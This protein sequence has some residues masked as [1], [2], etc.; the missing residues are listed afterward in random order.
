[1][2]S[3]QQKNIVVEDSVDHMED[4][5][6]NSMQ[7]LVV[8]DSV[9]Q[10]EDNNSNSMELSNSPSLQMTNLQDNPK[11]SLNDASTQN[12]QNDHQLIGKFWGDRVEEADDILNSPIANKVNN[13]FTLVMSKSQKKK[14]K[15]E[16]KKF[17]CKSWILITLDIRQELQSL[18]IFMIRLKILYWNARV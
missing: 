4:S 6:S 7:N 9:D 12:V 14:N 3:P 16:L 15:G 10:L 11:F 2:K 13:E 17:F 8:A 1:M 5:I 18:N